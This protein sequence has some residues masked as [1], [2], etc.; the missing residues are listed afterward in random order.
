[1]ALGLAEPF[2]SDDAAGRRR[3]EG[4]SGQLADGSVNL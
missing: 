2:H 1:L 3:F 4:C